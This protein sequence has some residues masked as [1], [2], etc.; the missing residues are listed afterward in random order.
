MDNPSAKLREGYANYNRSEYYTKK[1]NSCTRGISQA[2]LEMMMRVALSKR[3]VKMTVKMTYS[4]R[5]ALVLGLTLC[6]PAFTGGDAWELVQD[7]RDEAQGG[8]R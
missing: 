6:M 5:M 7:K 1:Q 2:F 3:P 4:L 8:S